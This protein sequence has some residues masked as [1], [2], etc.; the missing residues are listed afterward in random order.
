MYNQLGLTGANCDTLYQQKYFFWSNYD[1]DFSYIPDNEVS[2]FYIT[3][4]ILNIIDAPR[5]P[6]IE[7]MNEFMESLPVYSNEYNSETPRND[8]LDI[9]TI[10]RVVM[11][12]YS[13][14]PIPE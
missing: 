6:F 8:E 11:E 5:D 2:F 4:V 10:D 9:L 3:Y 1:A 13:P 7:K 14:S 12:E